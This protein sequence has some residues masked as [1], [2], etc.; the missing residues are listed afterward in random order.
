MNPATS[1][2]APLVLSTVFPFNQKI[3]PGSSFRDHILKAHSIKMTS[4]K[5]AADQKSSQ[6]KVT[7]RNT[8]NSYSVHTSTNSPPRLTNW[9]KRS[10]N[11][12]RWEKPRLNAMCVGLRLPVWKGV[13]LVSEESFLN[14]EGGRMWFEYLPNSALLIPPFPYSIPMQLVKV[15]FP[16]LSGDK[17][18]TICR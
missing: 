18:P 8:A 2:R 10:E 1:S 12:R 11:R 13:S 9:P 4:L 15:Q 14:E 3:Y 5:K 17:G 6:K 16:F 7:P